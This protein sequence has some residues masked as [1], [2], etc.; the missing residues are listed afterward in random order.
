MELKTFIY[1]K[2]NGAVSERELVVLSKPNSNY[3]GLDVTEMHEDNFAEFAEKFNA[4]KTLHDKQMRELQEE[5]GLTYSGK[6]FKPELMS[7]ESSEWI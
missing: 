4:L 2:A 1:T 3:F 7:N 5:Y 6:A